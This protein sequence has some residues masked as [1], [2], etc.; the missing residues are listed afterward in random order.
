MGSRAVIKFDTNPLVT[1]QDNVEPLVRKSQQNGEIQLPTPADSQEDKSNAGSSFERFPIANL[2]AAPQ[3]ASPEPSPVPLT[4]L[5]GTV[6]DDDAMDWTPSQETFQPNVNPG[7]LLPQPQPA[8]SL[9]QGQLPPAPKPPSWQLRNRNPEPA[10]KP[11]QSK[12]NP[13]HNAPA[14]QP[15][16]IDST[17]EPSERSEVVMAPPKFFPPSDLRAD[18]GLESL[19]DRTFSLAEEPS[20]VRKSQGFANEREV[21]LPPGRRTSYV[22]KCGLLSVTL[23][24]LAA[25]QTSNMPR[26]TVETTVLAASFLIAGFSLLESLM[27]PMA[28]WNVIDLLFPMLELVACVYLA[29]L[30][31]RETYS[32][33]QFDRIG[34]GLAAFMLVQELLALRGALTSTASS[35]TSTSTTE[36]QRAAKLHDDSNPA[37]S[38]QPTL[39][40]SRL[41][42]SSPPKKPQSRLGVTNGNSFPRNNTSN[43][44]RAPPSKASQGPSNFSTA[45]TPD[46]SYPQSPPSLSRFNNAS[47]QSNFNGGANVNNNASQPMPYPP[48]FSSFSRPPADAPPVSFSSFGSALPEKV[49][50][51]ASTASTTD[52]ASSNTSEPSSPQP[53]V[54]QHS[55][56][57]TRSR[58][59]ARSPSIT[60]LTL[61]DSPARQG[62]SR[63]SLRSRRG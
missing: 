33:I 22:L 20:E 55:P 62:M 25:T 6:G 30:R 8:P 18:T 7:P 5:S 24:M 19:F 56:I 61:D 60:G 11:V 42:D 34:Q 17:R 21:I 14:L 38:V 48:P 15:A 3:K 10:M 45:P 63:Y 54:R 12:P 26:N 31:S 29:V 2:A 35:T 32:Q 44:H 52:Y 57:S 40:I 47:S 41:G 36:P 28:L 50:S 37:S 1:W 27:R 51:T 4:P 13:F 58:P 9:F 16:P 53:R 23:I 59:S 49:L 43:S 39:G 46:R